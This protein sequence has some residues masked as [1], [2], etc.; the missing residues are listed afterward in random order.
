MTRLNTILTGI[1]ALFATLTGI[2]TG[3]N[4]LKLDC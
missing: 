4:T 1:G 2:F 3:L